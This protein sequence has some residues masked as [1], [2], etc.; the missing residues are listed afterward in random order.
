M[1]VGFPNLRGYFE[2]Y[3]APHM[4]TDIM[5]LQVQYKWT[6]N[7]IA[8]TRNRWKLKPTNKNS[9]QKSLKRKI[10]LDHKNKLL[11][12]NR[13]GR[14]GRMVS[15]SDDGCFDPIYHNGEI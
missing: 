13:G 12:S 9:E 1:P 5:H 15:D 2:N 14:G 7:F 11:F 6:E 10:K 8:E 4:Y 3:D